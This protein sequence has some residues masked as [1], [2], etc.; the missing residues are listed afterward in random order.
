MAF[1]NGHGGPIAIVDDDPGMC[2]LLQVL[3]REAGHDVLVLESGRDA[4]E[5]LVRERPSL[6]V[7]D[8][9]LPGFS[10][11]EVCRGLRERVGETL[12]ILFLSGDRIE[13]HDRV[14][15]LLIGGD[16]YLVKPFSADELL[17]RVHALLRRQTANGRA[18]HLTPREHEVLEL[19][20][21]G[22]A[23]QDIA[24][25]LAISRKTVG[26]HI[27]R[28]LSKLGVHSRAQA[29]AVAYRDGLLRVSV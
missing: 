6:V 25:L 7:L 20:A 26:T 16:D 3:L 9:N 11:Y 19:L 10:G 2:E 23:Q 18:A 14:A 17:A 24:R 27:E 1:R 28:I 29:V 8:V 5:L 4:V 22:H 13:A 12:P 21:D 15:G